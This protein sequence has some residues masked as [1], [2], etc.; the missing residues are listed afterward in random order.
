MTL[1]TFKCNDLIPLHFK[2][3]DP[4]PS[5]ASRLE[6]WSMTDHEYFWK[7]V[8]RHSHDGIWRRT[9][10]LVGYCTCTKGRETFCVMTSGKTHRVAC[11]FHQSCAVTVWA[12][13]EERGSHSNPLPVGCASDYGKDLIPSHRFASIRPVNL[14]RQNYTCDAFKRTYAQWCFVDCV[15][16]FVY[17][18]R[19]LEKWIHFMGS[20]NLA[21]ISLLP[22][23]IT[24]HNSHF[25][26]IFV[27]SNSIPYM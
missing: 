22:S 15:C 4:K 9:R 11:C 25:Q 7:E 21:A 3:L 14:L 12:A 23:L 18:C 17:T 27:C 6:P 20:L 1:N 10:Q 16:V 5:L 19:F 2:G 24:R 13:V 26:N 8:Q